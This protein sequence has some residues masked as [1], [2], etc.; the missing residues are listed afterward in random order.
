MAFTIHKQ[1]RNYCRSQTTD[2]QR[3]RPGSGSRNFRFLVV[4]LLFMGN[5][6][7]VLLKNNVNIAIV[8]IQ[9]K[10][11]TTAKNITTS[12]NGIVEIHSK[13]NITDGSDDSDDNI[14]TGEN[15]TVEIQSKENITVNNVTESESKYN[16]DSK[17]VGIIQ[18]SYA[19][20]CIFTV[21]GAVII[22]KLGG[23]ITYGTSILM[24]AI[25]NMITPV[26][27]E[28]DFFVFLGSRVVLGAFDG[29]AYMGGVE[30]LSRW[31]PVRERSRIMSLSFC[32]IYVGVAVAYPICGIIANSLGWEAIFYFSGICGII[33]SALWFILVRNQPSKDKWMSKKEQLYIVENTQTTPRK[34]IV[35]PYMKIVTSPQVWAFCMGK[36]TYSWGF[37]LLVVCFPLYVRDMTGQ[38]TDKVGLISSIP[39]FVC[40]CTIPLAGFLLDLWQNN[41]NLSV[42][43]IHKIVMCTGFT[44]GAVLFLI[45]S[46]SSNFTLSMTCF[47]LIKFI[48]S[49]NY[50]V[51][52]LVCLYIHVTAS[53]QCIGWKVIMVVH[54][55]YYFDTKRSRIHSTK[56]HLIRME[57]LFPFIGRNFFRRSYDIFDLRFQ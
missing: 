57:H 9:S 28:F 37:T 35:H 33:W 12:E 27:L 5:L 36:F 50:L 22:S 47:V 41:T 8:E 38:T 45:A 39:N 2:K 52:Q 49:F 13:E 14:I 53:F 17:T 54:C 26:C 40:I 25:I 20:G 31:A 1:L 6:N 42:T 19:Y 32:G 30:V 4:T 24:M 7:I 11:N 23:A 29:L 18:S 55:Q 56:W 43:Q 46:Q 10:K 21:F 3:N 48:I 16:W 15:T 51:L 44:S 34:Q